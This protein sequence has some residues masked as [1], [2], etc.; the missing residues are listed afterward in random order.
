MC[1]HRWPTCACV[2]TRTWPRP[3]PAAAASTAPPCLCPPAL[4]T[5]PPSRRLHMGI[6][7]HGSSVQCVNT[8][9]PSS[10]R[11]S[12]HSDSPPF[13]LYTHR[14]THTHTHPYPHHHPQRQVP[15]MKQ[16]P[17]TPPPL[18]AP[19]SFSSLPPPR[20]L[21]ELVAGV[22]GSKLVNV[23]CTLQALH[24]GC[25]PG[26]PIPLWSYDHDQELKS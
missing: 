7:S 22:L 5:P 19:A 26:S 24:A 11:L 18:H 17:K 23:E 10:S 25:C 9:E 16:G 14:R 13:P 12:T 15:P 4:P 20:P 3:P 2:C 21:L 8:Q 6:H 1:M